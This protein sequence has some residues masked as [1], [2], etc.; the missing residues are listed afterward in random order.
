MIEACKAAITEGEAYQLCL[1]TEATVS[2]SPDPVATYLAL[3][4][5]SP[6]HHGALLRAGGVSLLSASPEQFLSVSPD[7]VVE[8]KPIKGTRPR[9]ISPEADDSLRTELVE[10]EKER[11]ENLMIVDLMRNDIG[12]ISEIGSVTVTS[13]LEVESYAQ[14]HQLVSTVRGT[15]AAGLRPVDAV[16]AC[17]P[18]GSMTGAPK[19]SA[20]LI[21]DTLEHRPRGIYSGAF[22]YFG[23]DGSVDL[24]MVIRSIVIDREKLDRGR[25]RRHHRAL[26]PARG[27]RRGQAQGGGSAVGAGR[28]VVLS[29]RSHS[30]AGR[31]TAIAS[32]R[33]ETR[34]PLTETDPLSSGE[35]DDAATYD[36][37]A[38]QAKWP[39]VWEALAPF[40]SD[41]DGDTRPRKYVMDMF[42]YPSGDLHMGHAEAYALA[43]VVARYWRLQGFNVLHPIGWD[44][45]GLPAENA[46]IK[47]GVDPVEW[48]YGNIAQQSA[49]MRRYAT[50]VDWTRELATSDP[51]YY[52]WNQWLF[53]K[54]YEKGLAYRKE[55][56]VNW[57][58]VDQTVLANEQVLADGTSRP[59]GCRGGQEEAHP[60]VLQDHRLRRPAAR[61]PEP[62]RGVVAEQGHRD[63][64]Q[65]DRTL[66]R[67]GRRLRDRGPRAEGVGVHDAPRHPVRRDASWWSLPTPSSRPSWP[68]GR[69]PRC[70]PRSRSTSCRPR[71]TRRSS[72]RMRDGRRP[73][74]RS[75]ASRSTP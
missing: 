9:G 74:S 30:S 53:L 56:W 38:L 26:G 57:D 33:T 51:E 60:V 44:S 71:R 70:R 19:H 23:F 52:K 28:P 42:S 39:P 47:R 14:V 72:G 12:R 25:R 21:L 31:S 64:A 65:L 16:R 67:G 3:R 1:T 5:L 45:F 29:T 36:P 7:R 27:A 2:V 32:P 54:L 35:R 34:T 40:Q 13:L 59:L 62:A 69:R 20:T 15:L 37:K 22:G 43:D 4:S 6:T 10:S 55:S 63:A 66:H 11:A 41:L 24:A 58:P 46:A 61:R 75:S 50:S 49:S 8:S 68:R 73:A 48:T 17:F 18:A